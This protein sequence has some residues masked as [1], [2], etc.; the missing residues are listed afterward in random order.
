MSRFY[1]LSKM[2]LVTSHRDDKAAFKARSIFQAINSLQF[3]HG[4]MRNNAFENT[5]TFD[6]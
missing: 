6:G 5:D 4:K 3:M 2:M 1:S